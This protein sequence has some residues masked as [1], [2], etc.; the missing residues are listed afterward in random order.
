M[1][2]KFIT[3]SKVYTD[4]D[5]AALVIGTI[6]KDSIFTCIYK[7][8]GWYQLKENAWVYGT[9]VEIVP[10]KLPEVGS[11]NRY[12]GYEN[13][14]LV[15]FPDSD[16]DS[17]SSSEEGEGKTGEDEKST[18]EKLKEEIYKKDADGKPTKE[19]DEE[20][21]KENIKNGKYK[22]TEVMAKV[23]GLSEEEIN[24]TR[25]ASLERYE[26]D[27]K[28]AEE[29]GEDF[30]KTKEDYLAEDLTKKTMDKVKTSAVGWS[31]DLFNLMKE[32][33]KAS[34]EWVGN[35]L[36][37]DNNGEA[38]KAQTLRILS[39]NAMLGMPYQFLPWVDIR[40]LKEDEETE[41]MNGQHHLDNDYERLGQKYATKIAARSPMLVIAPG[42]PLFMSA[43]SSS[44]K[45]SMINTMLTESGAKDDAKTYL[46]AALG[47]YVANPP[48]FYSYR[49]NSAMYYAYVNSLCI[50]AARALNLTNRDYPGAYYSNAKMQYLGRDLEDIF[51][52]DKQTSYW[53]KKS[54]DVDFR[55]AIGFYINSDTQISES[56]SNSTTMSQIASKING[57]SDLAREMQ[58]LAG[59]SGQIT[60]KMASLAD[61]AGNTL[62]SFG[63]SFTE[64]LG[65]SGSLINIVG[66]SIKNIIAGSK[67]IFP[68][69]WADST[70]AR[71]Y[72]VT[73]KLTSPDNDDLSLYHNIIVPLIHLIVLAFPR[74]GNP[75]TYNSPFLIRAAYKS[76]FHIDMG[77]ISSISITKGAEGCWNAHG[78]PTC[79]DVTL[80]FKEL[81]GIMNLAMG[82]FLDKFS[83]QSYELG[84]NDVL[85]SYITTL[86]GLNTVESDLAKIVALQFWTGWDAMKVNTPQRI[87]NSV[88]DYASMMASRLYNGELTQSVK[89]TIF[90]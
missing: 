74:G 28:A 49:Q 55:G 19:I 3:K 79:V 15:S 24:E 84:K 63:K 40:L 43:A 78:I 85:M 66:S 71:D 64:A 31:E 17:D 54:I 11:I 48:K 37:G 9:N 1:R 29:K 8:N 18:I 41:P 61:Q 89:N 21:L 50:A 36:S 23:S 42:E 57:V 14:R 58:F 33:A 30:D 87:S 59:S 10:D 62:T 88:W 70:F 90:N 34:A 69:I 38:F 22:S 27:K 47:D 16:E 5:K 81:Y 52:A 53:A 76:F 7:I 67:M 82:S 25:K 46:S 72:Q 13:Y 12:K 39:T 68:E 56:M 75:N 6:D 4:C 60:N 80:T 77:I 26:K 83:D 2:I 65:G 20:K 35:L 32:D 86:C 44:Q 73:I 51:T 45:E